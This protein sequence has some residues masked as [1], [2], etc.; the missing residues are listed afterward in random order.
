LLF[1]I[2]AWGSWLA[3]LRAGPLAWVED[4]I[5]GIARD[6]PKSGIYLLVTGD[7]ELTTSR[8]YGSL[9][10]RAYFPCGSTEES[11]AAWPRFTL[12][13]PV[14]ARA[15]VAGPIL[16]DGL[17]EAQFAVPPEGAAWP[18]GTVA[19]PAHPVFRVQALPRRIAPDEVLIR[20]QADAPAGQAAR[21]AGQ[22]AP[23]AF[24]GVSAAILLGVGGDELEPITVSLPAGGGVVLAFGHR[25]AGKSNLMEVLPSLNPGIRWLRAAPG[26]DPGTFYA[27]LHRQSGAGSLD[28]GAIVLIDDADRLGGEA[29]ELAADLPSLGIG[30][31][32]TAAYGEAFTQRLPLA[33]RARSEGRGILLS[34]RHPADGDLFRIRVEPGPNIPG[35]AILI[36]DGDSRAFQIP[37][38][39]PGQAQA[40]QAAA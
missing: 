38:A 36:Q 21:A 6:G 8:L 3:L 20:A 26:S 32:A 22:V 29:A 25:G 24:R 11:R 2:T 7:R 27:G 10:N 4:L 34:P 15:M 23:G 39:D 17:G 28:P 33:G 12:P 18:Y 37:V 5:H 35:R 19:G 14:A 1:V 16:G 13:P 30:V 40:R 9:P 31:I